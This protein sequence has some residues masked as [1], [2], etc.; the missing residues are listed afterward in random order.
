MKTNS[1]RAEVRIVSETDMPAI[2]RDKVLTKSRRVSRAMRLAK[3]QL[4]EASAS[5]VARSPKSARW[6]CLQVEPGADFKVEAVLVNA[7]V[8]VLA[9]REK[10]VTVRRGRSIDGER[11]VIPGYIM[12]QIVPSPRAFDGLKQ[13]KGVFDF[14]RGPNGYH[15]V[16]ERDILPFKMLLPADIPRMETD[17]SIAEKDQCEIIMGPFIGY[18]CTVTAVRWGHTARAS[19]A[20]KLGGKLFEIDSMPVA[21]LKKL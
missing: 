19:V 21:F 12:V 14:V 10:F 5:V 7:G 8:N 2:E 13:Q 15:I 20:I 16:A 11:P 17:K 9:P 6:F 1:K 3:A 18:E 4:G